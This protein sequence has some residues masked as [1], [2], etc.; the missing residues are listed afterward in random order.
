MAGISILSKLQKYEQF[1]S[2]GTENPSTFIILINKIKVNN[3]VINYEYENGYNII[4]N[5]KP[6]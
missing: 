1:T 5:D 4:F 3:K 2:S 6:E